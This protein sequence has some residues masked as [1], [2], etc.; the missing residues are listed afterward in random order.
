MKEDALMITILLA[1]SDPHIKSKYERIYDKY[2]ESWYRIANSILK[3]EYL[4]Q[5][6]LQEWAAL[7]DIYDLEIG[8]SRG[9]PKYDKIISGIDSDEPSVFIF[10]NWQSI[11][12]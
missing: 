10:Y 3:D 11:S 8:A 5:D 1:L 9:A 2:V 7:E 12:V 4:A 6:V